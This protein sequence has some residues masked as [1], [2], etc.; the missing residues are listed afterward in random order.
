MFVWVVAPACVHDMPL[1]IGELLS[2]GH[3]AAAAAEDVAGA[4]AHGRS[5]QNNL[6]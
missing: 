5:K 1:S 3:Q 6:A 4:A 2:I